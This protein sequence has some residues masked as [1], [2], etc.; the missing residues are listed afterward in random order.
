MQDIRIDVGVDTHL[1]V[2]LGDDYQIPEN[3]VLVF[4]I[5]NAPFARTEAVVER[6]FAYNPEQA[7]NKIFDIYITAK[8]SV[9]ILD[10]AEYDF[11]RIILDGNGE[12]KYRFK[13]TDNG[14]VRLRKGV[15]GGI[16]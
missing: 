2:N 15:G 13:M 8:E 9:Q 3:E 11:N 10:N 12:E 5:K 6:K 4:T 1:T 14:K 7:E 16:A